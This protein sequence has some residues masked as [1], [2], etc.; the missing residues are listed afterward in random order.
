MNTCNWIRVGALNLP[1]KRLGI[2]LNVTRPVRSKLARMHER[3]A[4]LGNN[5]KLDFYMYTWRCKTWNAEKLVFK[6][7]SN[8]EKI[9]NLIEIIQRV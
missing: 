7:K 4:A 5:L 6:L 8:K 3:N 2:F 9:Q 1:T